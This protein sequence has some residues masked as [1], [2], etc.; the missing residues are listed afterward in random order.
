[1]FEFLRSRED[2]ECPE[3]GIAIALACERRKVRQI[4]VVA[5]NFMVILS[6]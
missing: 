2:S 6:E 1:M 3:K 5:A 4:A